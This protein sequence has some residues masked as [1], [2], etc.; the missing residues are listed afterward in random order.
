MSKFSQIALGIRALKPVEIPLQDGVVATCSV[1]PLLGYEEAKILADARAYAKARGVDDPRDGNPIYELGVW[2]HTIVHGCVDSDDA[3]A[4][5]FD[6]GADQILD[7]LDRDRIALLFEQQQTWQD[8][9]SPRQRSMS[10]E[11]YKATVVALAMSGDDA[12]I[13]FVLSRPVLR[14]SFMRSMAKAL[15]TL[16]DPN[17]P[18]GSPFA[19]STATA[20]N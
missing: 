17:S 11:E 14:A 6:G 2:V 3:S 13:P 5:F 9:C 1:R 7:R 12:D 20:T 8:E 15:V 4:P 19:S 10:W 16:A 18:F